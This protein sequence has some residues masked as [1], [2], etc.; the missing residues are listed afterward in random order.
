MTH[1]PHRLVC[2]P[3][4][5]LSY[6]IALC[7]GLIAYAIVLQNLLIPLYIGL[8]SITIHSLSLQAPERLKSITRFLFGFIAY[9]ATLLPLWPDSLTN[10]W[11][12][13]IVLAVTVSTISALNQ[14]SFGGSRAVAAIGTISFLLFLRNI[15]LYYDFQPPIRELTISLAFVSLMEIALSKRYQNSN[16]SPHPELIFGLTLALTASFH[17]SSLSLAILLSILPLLS[18]LLRN[19]ELA[20]SANE[21]T[22]PA[23]PLTPPSYANKK[24]PARLVTLPILLACLLYL[25]SLKIPF[26]ADYVPKYAPYYAVSLAQK[27]QQVSEASDLEDEKIETIA[28]SVISQKFI[29]TQVSNLTESFTSESPE[30]TEHTTPPNIL[31][32]RDS[33]QRTPKRNQENEYGYHPF[34]RD[35]AS[36]PTTTY[37][38]QQ[39]DSQAQFTDSQWERSSPVPLI[40][41][42]RAR[43]DSALPNDVDLG[44][45]SP[46][47][48]TLPPSPNTNNAPPTSSDSQSPLD[49]FESSSDFD[50]FLNAFNR[51]EQAISQALNLQGSDVSAL[52]SQ[53]PLVTVKL[54]STRNAP[55]KLYLRSNVLD[56]ASESGFGGARS[57]DGQVSM[58]TPNAEIVN[59]QSFLT[60]KSELA[61]VTITSIPNRFPTLPLPA[62]FSQF[63]IFGIDEINL[64]PEDRVALAP[65]SDSPITY[66]LHNADLEVTNRERKTSYLSKEYRDRMLQV[67]LNRKDRNYLTALA[68]RVGGSRSSSL[69]FSY[70]FANYFA[71]RH[72]Y[73]YFVTIPEGEGH[74]VVRWLKNESPGLCSNYASAFTLL[75]RSRGI[76]TRV[77]SGFASNEYDPREKR[78][79]LR[80]NNAHAW[81]EYLNESN[82]WI[83]FDPTPGISEA[84]VRRAASYVS[85]ANPSSLVR[86]L[87]AE[88]Q[89]TSQPTTANEELPS[90]LTQTETND[91]ITTPQPIES[92]VEKSQS[93][94]PATNYDSPFP[95]PDTA[96]KALTDTSASPAQS[97][98]P[99]EGTNKVPPHPSHATAQ[100]LSD[101]NQPPTPP[102]K[103]SPS[104]PPW[105]LLL[106]LLAFGLPALAFAISK[107]S[108]PN[109]PAQLLLR[110]KAG[111]LLAQL[112]SLIQIH[113]LNADP[114]WI[115]TR[116]TLE[117]QRYGREANATLIQDIAVKIALLAKRKKHS[118]PQA[119]A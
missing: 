98:T 3:Q 72:D 57:D 76:P 114:I 69:Q 93:Q 30:K 101:P 32:N 79:I 16:D 13:P 73:S 64:Y 27:A 91:A 29:E 21:H 82:Q 28:N 49:Q 51:P 77:V 11:G 116:A 2:F 110:H 95:L 5:A 100:E 111:R 19:H 40:T 45:P 34:K 52:L 75:A 113:E 44:I 71:N 117:A 9:L 60:S 97:D 39:D 48:G 80:Q 42:P 33:Y 86:L 35:R 47:A 67:P 25:L 96:P 105:I 83:R 90:W 20:R 8:G 65:Q 17:F 4:L 6:W 50:R 59:L 88:R 36:S 84:E 66:R 15:F 115:N 26:W 107:N 10:Y 53:E 62:S 7:S 46:V 70:R 43:L 81:V 23:T 74:P 24:V 109:K 89:A 104:S 61:T 14:N 54:N 55:R 85:E 87:Q 56:T 99:V 22:N 1:L 31:S 92:P 102:A 68:K 108:Q 94:N 18:F 112:D 103:D 12:L 41:P 38:Y 58:S 37:R 78:Y 106:L 119:R 63:Q 118:Q